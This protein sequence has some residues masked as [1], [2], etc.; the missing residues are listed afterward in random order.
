M[1]GITKKTYPYFLGPEIKNEFF[2]NKKTK[3]KIILQKL[4]KFY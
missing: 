2:L 1:T 3:I 4:S